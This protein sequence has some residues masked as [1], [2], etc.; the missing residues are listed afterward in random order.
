MKRVPRKIPWIE[1]DEQGRPVLPIRV[2]V[3]TVTNLGRIRSDSPHFHNARYIWP[4]GFEAQRTYP[5]MKHAERYALYTCRVL[6]KGDKPLVR[7]ATGRHRNGSRDARLNPLGSGG[8]CR[9]RQFELVADD[10]PEHPI[11]AA[12][13][14]GTRACPLGRR[15][16]VLAHRDAPCCTEFLGGGGCAQACGRRC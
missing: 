3:L 8:V 10:D 12:T 11:Q 2:G 14:T 5:S 13:A 15:S 7:Q 9:A 6:E 4:V 1:R 16:L